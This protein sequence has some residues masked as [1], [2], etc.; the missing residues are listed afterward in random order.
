MANK[1]R[2]TDKYI[3]GR[4]RTWRRRKNGRRGVGC[5]WNSDAGDG[6]FPLRLL[7]ISASTKTDAGK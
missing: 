7:D 3:D 1:V 2:Q 5:D 6:G 4:T